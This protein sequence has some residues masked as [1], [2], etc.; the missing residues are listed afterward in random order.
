MMLVPTYL[1]KSPIH[2]IGIY[3]RDFIAKGTR[4]W[5]FSPGFDQVFSDAA[6]AALLPV[7]REAILFYCF[8]EPGLDGVVL[9]C[10][11]ARHYN[12]ADDPNCGA[13]DH[14]LHGYIS[15]YA[16]RDIAAGEELTYSVEEDA[17]AARKM[18]G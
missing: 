4:V 2:G 12:F 16:L 14:V 15:T 8:I 3:A 5:E 10:D 18:G 9:C 1:D 11:N 17:D 13:A 7:Q 6:L